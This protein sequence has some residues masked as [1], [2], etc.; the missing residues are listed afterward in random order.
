VTTQTVVRQKR[1]RYRNRSGAVRI[2]A[3]SL[4]VIFWGPGILIIGVGI[5]TGRG[6]GFG[7][8]LL[9]GL[10]ALMILGGLGF[11]GPALQPLVVLTTHTLR[12]PRMLRRAQVTPL[13]EVTGVG[14][15]YKRTPSMPTPLGW[16]LYLW[17]T[18]DVPRDLGIS[19]Q[20]ASWL[21]PPD[22]VREKFLAV[23]RSDAERGRRVDSYHFSYHFDPVTQTDPEKIAA[24]YAGR[25]A[26]D[27][28]DQ[29]LAYQGPSGFLATRQDQKHVP[30]N[31][32]HL[33]PG[34]SNAPPPGWAY[35]SP[36]GE[37]GRTTGKPRDRQWM[38]PGGPAPRSAPP[39]LLIRLQYRLRLIG[40]KL[41]RRG[42]E[43]HGDNFR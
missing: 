5:T 4:S 16:F 2:L 32:G 15:V 36:D 41:Q 1:V 8:P 42:C 25:V 28:Y 27:I 6:Q 29:V 19:Y 3:P 9:I 40:H 24:T 20:P 17:T 33:V 23:E 21:F 38:P 12:R 35:W 31:A 18:G 22:K 13:D 10:G 14:L 37:F 30:A 11:V 7:G 43:F 39:G 26:R 34:V